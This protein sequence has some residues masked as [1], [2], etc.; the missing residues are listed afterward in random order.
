M[1]NARIT[2]TDIKDGDVVRRKLREWE[3]SLEEQRK[4]P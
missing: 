3:V 4:R 2:D 1:K